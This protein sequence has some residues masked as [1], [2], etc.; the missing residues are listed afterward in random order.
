MS[1]PCFAEKRDNM[2]FNLDDK[3]KAIIDELGDCGSN[4]CQLVCMAFED[5]FGIDREELLRIAAPFGGGMGYFGMTC[6]ALAGAGIVFSNH[7]GTGFINQKE[8]KQ[9]FYNAVRE[10]CEAFEARSGAATCTALKKMQAAG[11]GL[12]CR[13]LIYLGAEVAEEYIRKYKDKFTDRLA[14]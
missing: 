4:C 13:E 8:Y 14:K 3:K 6:G 10:M 1:S 9:E 7:F 11:Y 5:E 2:N 12:K